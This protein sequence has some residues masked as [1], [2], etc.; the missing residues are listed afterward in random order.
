[1]STNF[2][3]GA[4]CLYHKAAVLRDTIKGTAYAMKL[5]GLVTDAGCFQHCN[6][7]CLPYEVRNLLII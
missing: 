2:R 1:M 4:G 7:P 5:L 3:E 6:E